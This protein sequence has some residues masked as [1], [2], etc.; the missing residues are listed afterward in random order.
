M[1]EKPDF[2][3]NEKEANTIPATVVD[4][5]IS[6]D[7]TYSGTFYFEYQDVDRFSGKVINAWTSSSFTMLLTLKTLKVSDDVVFLDV[8]NAVLSDSSFGTGSSGVDPVSNFGSQISVTLPTNPAE[9][10]INSSAGVSIYFNLGDDF[11]TKMLEIKPGAIKVSSDGMV[12]TQNPDWGK[13]LPANKTETPAWAAKTPGMDTTFRFGGAY[14]SGGVYDR[15]FKYGEWSL[16]K[17]SS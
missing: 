7:G 11:E 12:I 14:G 17:I 8:T 13:D 4:D 10:Q 15:H 3:S 2:F 5:K 9:Q 16:S 1:R 6:Y